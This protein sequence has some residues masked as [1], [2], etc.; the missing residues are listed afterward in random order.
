MRLKQKKQ[1]AYTRIVLWGLIILGLFF[2]W[3]IRRP[4]LQEYN[5]HVCA[6]YGYQSDCQ[7]R[8]GAL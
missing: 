5:D 8:L 7:T 3:M 6:T 4:G 1:S 2:L